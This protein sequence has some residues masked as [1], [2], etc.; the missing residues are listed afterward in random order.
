MAGMINHSVSKLLMII[1]CNSVISIMLIIPEDI[2]F[3]HA[4]ANNVSERKHQMGGF[5]VSDNI[6]FRIRADSHPY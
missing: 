6:D 1:D 2:L 3:K 4:T 5:E